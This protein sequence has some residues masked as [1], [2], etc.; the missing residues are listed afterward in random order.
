M[1]TGTLAGWGTA[2]LLAAAS[3]ILPQ[4][5]ALAVGGP[6]GA[7]TFGS[8]QCAQAFTPS[9]VA[10]AAS[11]ASTATAAGARPGSG[12]QGGVPS[13]CTGTVSSQFGCVPPGCQV[14]A[15]TLAC[16]LTL[17]GLAGGL[18]SAGAL[19][20]LARRSLIL[21]PPAIASSPPSGVPQ[22]VDLPVW[23]WVNPAIWAPRSAT[24][25]VT[26]ER[27]TVTAAPVA[28]TWRMGDGSVVACHGPG[29]PYTSRYRAASSSPDCGHTY[30]RSSAG[31]P[32]GAYHVTAAITWNITWQ[33]AG[34]TGG[35]GGALPPLFSTAAAALRVAESQAVNTAGGSR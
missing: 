4:P 2:A 17:P 25:A 31:Q 9:C 34:G 3:A 7:G 12:G 15:A 14:S 16:P 1:L 29:T 22:L 5:A 10:T 30:R 33:A 24:A 23:L 6:G 32:G 19:A 8:V 35:T 26:G 18:P 20:Q 28:V 27:V 21:P 11:P 13:G